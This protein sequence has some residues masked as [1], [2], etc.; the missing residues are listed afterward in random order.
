[1]SRKKSFKI[2]VFG[3][4]FV[5]FLQIGNNLLLIPLIIA[6]I[7]PNQYGYWLASGGILAWASACDL[8]LAGII[9]QRCS[10]Y[11]GRMSTGKAVEYFQVGLLIYCLLLLLLLAVIYG[12][13]FLLDPLLNL[14][15]QQVTLFQHTFL[16]A[17]A[18]MAL[19]VLKNIF[20][21]YLHAAQKPTGDIVAGALG[22]LLNLVFVVYLL[23]CTSAGLWAIPIG[24]FANHFASVIVIL[25]YIFKESPVLRTKPS[26]S[27]AILRDYFTVSPVLFVARLGSQMT[28][29]IEPTLIVMFL[30]PELATMFTIAKRLVEVMMGF[31]NSVRGGLIA[32]FSH[33][34]GE[35]GAEATVNLLDRILQMTIGISFAIALVYVATNRNFVDLW[36][37]PEYYIGSLI[38][39]FMSLEAF[40][41]SV[42]DS[43]IHLVGALGELRRSSVA[44]LAESVIKVGLMF[45]FLPLLG[46][47]GLPLASLISSTG[48]AGYSICR[49]RRTLHCL[50]IDMNH[51]MLSFL[52][53]LSL[54]AG[55][56]F[57]GWFGAG[58]NPWLWLPLHLLLSAI[59]A[60][61]FAVW[62]FP[63][64]RSELR[65][66]ISKLQLHLPLFGSKKL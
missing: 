40:S 60:V 35:K 37:G 56:S 50:R 48:K 24:M 53:A 45:I 33:F 31:A 43:M 27:R 26:I 15:A 54:L 3:G 38:C 7:G 23:T 20:A 14:P 65:T 49:L 58:Q 32:G 51:P 13:S 29:K 21:A 34:F 22:Q 12:L 6:K 30:T 5:R 41:K 61:F 46:V 8:G 44:L 39:V 17:G 64:I 52:L 1:M 36:V 63:F 10:L 55:A 57:L 59:C 16:L 2:L 66:T 19:S 47:V 4:W 25:Y 18:A 11:L 9:K 62:A 42:G 28:A